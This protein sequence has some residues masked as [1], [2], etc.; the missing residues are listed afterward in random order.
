MPAGWEAWVDYLE[1]NFKK[2]LTEVSAADVGHVGLDIAGLV[3]GIGEGAD[4]TNAIWYIKNGQYLNAAF[5]IISMVPE[6]GDLIGKGSKYFLGGSKLFARFGPKIVRYWD[7]AKIII[8]NSKV[9][10]PHINQLDYAF[11]QAVEKSKQDLNSKHS[12]GMG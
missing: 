7:S 1:C 5:S 2:W 8:N 4:L 10:R 3:P 6:V 9:L 12:S 11:R